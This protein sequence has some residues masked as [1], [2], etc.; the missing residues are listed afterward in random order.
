M[1]ATAWRSF[2]RLRGGIGPRPLGRGLLLPVTTVLATRVQLGPDHR[3]DLKAIAR[4]NPLHAR[5]AR[6]CPR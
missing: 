2:D 5:P 1:T 6:L 4:R 3:R